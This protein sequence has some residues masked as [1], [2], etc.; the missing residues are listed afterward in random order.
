VLRLKGDYLAIATLGF[1][2]IIRVVIVNMRSLTN[3]ALGLKNIPGHT[4]LGWTTIYA[5]LTV[6]LLVRLVGSSYGRALKAIREDEVAAEAMGINV[7]YHKMMA[8]VVGAFLAGMGGALQGSLIGSIDPAMYKL[9][10]TFQI[11]LMVVLGGMGSITGTVIAATIVTALMEI[12][13]FVESPLT[14]GAFHLP[15]IPGMRMV[16]FSLLLIAVTLFYRQG[17]MGEKEFSWSMFQG[18]WWIKREV[19]RQ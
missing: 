5:G 18:R 17:I 7:F 16:V 6:L 8:F 12:L 2:E 3:G 1:A 4:N 14:I 10:L 19:T 13:R 15:G 9:P 11:L